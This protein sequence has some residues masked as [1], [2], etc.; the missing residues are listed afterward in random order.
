MRTVIALALIITSSASAAFDLVL[1]GG[2]VV[3]GTGQAPYQA[4]IGISGDKITAIGDL[5]RT[6]AQV[7][8][9]SGLVVAPGFID[10]HSHAD[11]ALRNPETAGIPGFL[12]QGVTTA[13]FGV[14]GFMNNETLEQYIAL[15]EQ[16]GIGLNF[17]SYIGHN[18][19]RQLTMGD[20]ARPPTDAEL[21][22]MQAM[23]VEGM[24]LGA[25]GLSSG[26]MYLPGNFAATEELIALAQMVAPFG[27][28]YDSHI[29]NPAD[30]LLGSHREALQIAAA[31]GIAAHPAHVKAVGAKNFGL[32]HELVRVFQDAIGA[33]QNVT[34]DVYPYDGAST[35]PMI[36]LLYPGDDPLGRAL[37]QKMQDIETGAAPPSEIPALI[38][39]LLSYWGDLKPESNVYAQAVTN[40]EQPREGQYSWVETVGYQSMRVVVS[41]S[42]QAV[43]RMLPELAEA[44]GLT[45]FELIR[46]MVVAEQGV[47]IVTLGAIQ[48]EDVRLLMKQPWAMIASDGEEVDPLH[49]RGRGTF[50][51]VLGRY[52]REWQV[53]SL[54]EAVHK[55][56]ALPARYLKLADRGV[57]AKGMVADITVFDA[58]RIVDHASWEEPGLFAEGVIHVLMAG[59]FALQ[60]EEPAPVRLGRFIPF[61]TH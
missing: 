38:G 35:R 60:D 13:V 1:K 49:P 9:V 16:G 41:T 36:A 15:A 37:F 59:R 7:I 23:V 40:T 39:E 42:E 57:L 31:A 10:V 48:E 33:G 47:P 51:R 61:M 3:D 19:I 2:I 5:D 50:P 11:G 27:G 4:D 43:G 44:R 22:S 21:A 28:R 26:L 45:P 12:K 14:D 46:Q 55:M 52:V 30:D 29:R 24:Q 8:D 18:S 53:F 6:S 54:E 58:A 34:I 17:M 25:I 32:G 20:A 56:T